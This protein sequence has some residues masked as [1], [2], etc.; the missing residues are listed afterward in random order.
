MLSFISQERFLTT[1][2][3]TY[4]FGVDLSYRRLAAVINVLGIFV[5]RVHRL[6][7]VVGYQFLFSVRFDLAIQL[8]ELKIAYEIASESEVS[9]H[10]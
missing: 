8:S 1:L 9:V 5:P 4:C 10:V 7:G 3:F 2:Y 6:R